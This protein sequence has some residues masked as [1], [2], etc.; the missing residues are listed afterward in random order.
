[1]SS[2]DLW[3]EASALTDASLT[4]P[5]QSRVVALAV[6]T[7]NGLE[8]PWDEF[9]VRL[10]AAIEGHPQRPYYDSWLA[11]L[12]R[13]V[14]DTAGASLSELDDHRMHVA[15]YRTR[16]AGH[17]DLEVFP[18]EVSESTLVELL[19]EV[20][21]NWWRQIRFGPLINGAV[22]ELRAPHRPKLSMLDGYLTIAFEQWHVHLCIGEHRGVPG[23]GVDPGLAK[24]RRC[25]HAELQRQWV[26]GAPRSWMFRMFNG[27][28]AQQLTILLPNPFLDDDHRILD[29]PRWSRLELWDRLRQR[30]LGLPSDPIDR[31]GQRFVHA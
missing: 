17:D 21:E 18:L 30:Y 22:Y 9:R 16:E 13:L 31:S 24:R 1:V 27:E 7:V 29:A 3:A 5:W 12:E 11:A 14:L 25:A 6:E 10:S 28:G 26:D 15:S 4:E 19:T 23:G 8:L 20:F 2:D